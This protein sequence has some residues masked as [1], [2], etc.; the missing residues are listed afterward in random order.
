LGE[1]VLYHD[2]DSIVYI[3]DP[4]EYNIPESDV[5]GKWSVEKFD[6]KDGGI[7]EF[8][9]L[10][11]KSYGMKANNGKHY[12]KV[13]GLSLKLAHEEFVNFAVMKH[14]VQHYL[15]TDHVDTIQVP[16]MTFTY[17]MGQDMIT[18]HY[19]KA[20][21]FQPELLKGKLKKTNGQLYPHGYCEG[22]FHEC[23]NQE[24]HT[25]G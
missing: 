16:Q 21:K 4:N 11:P 3:Y 9:G 2:T 24:A 12:V 5:W 7:R 13:K 14:Q 23:G 17:K 25:C 6:T 10:A 1:R 19:S 15:D 22:C 8:V 20:F 18:R